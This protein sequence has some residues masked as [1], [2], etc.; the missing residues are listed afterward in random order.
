MLIYIQHKLNQKSLIL[1]AI[2][3][4]QNAAKFSMQIEAV[5]VTK[6]R[7]HKKIAILPY[8]GW[9]KKS[10]TKATIDFSVLNSFMNVKT[11]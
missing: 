11:T 7:C 1:Y 6:I 8:A 9:K 10:Q 3:F 4:Q 5:S 2:H